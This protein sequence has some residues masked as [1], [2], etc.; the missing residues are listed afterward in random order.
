MRENV[1]SDWLAYLANASSPLCWRTKV[2]PLCCSWACS[3]GLQTTP[4]NEVECPPACKVRGFLVRRVIVAL[5]PQN[6]HVRTPNPRIHAVALG[7][8]ARDEH[9]RSFVP[10]N[11]PDRGHS[12]A[13]LAALSCDM[14]GIAYRQGSAPAAQVE[15]KTQNIQNTRNSSLTLLG[16]CAHEH[17]EANRQ[18]CHP[19]EGF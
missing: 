4:E 1:G 3:S 18:T 16:A 13:D 5:A 11:N 15:S 6:E 9:P 12:L 10:E 14:P 19:G 2:L 17:L 7:T 8:T